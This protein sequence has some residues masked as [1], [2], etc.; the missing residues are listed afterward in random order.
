M[1]VG[2]EG[3]VAGEGF[4]SGD[5]GDLVAAIGQPSVIKVVCGFVGLPEIAPD[6]EGS[7]LSALDFGEREFVRSCG[8]LVDREEGF[9]GIPLM[10]A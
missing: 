3:R 9:V 8:I 1:V 7:K 5:A 10:R 6:F 2:D 4:I